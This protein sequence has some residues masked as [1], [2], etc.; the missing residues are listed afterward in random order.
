MLFKNSKDCGIAKKQ[1]V[2]FMFNCVVGKD[3]IAFI[4]ESLENAN[5]LGIRCRINFFC[6]EFNSK[7]QKYALIIQG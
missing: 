6:A 7:F 3:N 1:G 5:S 2:N 4:D